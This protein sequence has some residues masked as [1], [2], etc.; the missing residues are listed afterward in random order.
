[1]GQDNL[2]NILLSKDARSKNIS[3]STK[4]G[5]RSDKSFWLKILILIALIALI[6]LFINAT[7]SRSVNNRLKSIESTLGLFDVRLSRLEKMEKNLASLDEQR[8]KFEVSLM[9]RIE[10]LE[11]TMSIKNKKDDE[12]LS[13]LHTEA[14][15]EKEP[16]TVQKEPVIKKTDK[17]RVHKVQPGETLYR[18]SL[19]YGLTVEELKR[20]NNIGPQ[21]VIVV[22]QELK[23]SSD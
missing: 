23:I 18:I 9:N 1:M 15:K 5:D 16:E 17:T 21:S 12:G 22:G 2:K 20:I 4:S 7:G 13:N 11:T 3:R 10:S 14:R 8:T 6:S 19:N